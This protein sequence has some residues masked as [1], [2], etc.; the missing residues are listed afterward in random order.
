MPD[1]LIKTAN[2]IRR[3]ISMHSIYNHEIYSL[4][5]NGGICDCAS[6]NVH[7]GDVPLKKIPTKGKICECLMAPNESSGWIIDVT[8]IRGG[9]INIREHMR[10][11]SIVI[12]TDVMGQVDIDVIVRDPANLCDTIRDII[13]V[14]DRGK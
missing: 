14:A 11:G 4:C 13:D 10:S 7:Y 8:P 6:I 12:D 2:E 9:V 1:D 5:M 3:A